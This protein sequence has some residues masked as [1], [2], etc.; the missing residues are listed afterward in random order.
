MKCTAN[1]ILKTIK[2]SVNL[3]K[4][5]KDGKV[6][7]TFSDDKAFAQY[8]FEHK[9]KDGDIVFSDARLLDDPLLAQSHHTRNI[10]VLHSSHLSGTQIKN[11][12][13][14]HLNIKKMLK[15]L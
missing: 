12:S 9:F 15:N 14:T 1:V 6:Y 2:N 8:Y 10:L 4:L 13:N 11:L 7:Q 3:V 5:F